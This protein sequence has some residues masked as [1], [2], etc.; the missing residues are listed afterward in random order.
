MARPTPFHPRTSAACQSWAWK[1]WAGHAAVRA[2]DLH[3][4][5]EYFGV[6][7]AAGM[8][9]VSPLYKYDLRGPDAAAL[10]AWLFSR[11]IAKLGV[12]R[13]AYG[14]LLDERGKVLDDGTVSRLG[15]EWF[16][17]TSSEP[18]RGWLV[19]NAEG[20]AVEIH[21]LTETVAAL[22]VQ[23]PASRAILTALWPGVEKL[24]FF[25]AIEVDGAIV[26]RTGYTG[27]LGYEIWVPA[28]EAVALWDALAHAG[29]RYDLRPF[30]LDAL[31]VLRIEAGFVLQGVDYLSARATLLDRRRSTPDE[32]GLGWTVDL[33]RAPFLGQAAIRAERARPAHWSLVGLELSWPGIERLYA[34][35]DLPPH[36]APVA[37][38]ESVPVYDETGRTQVGYA[39]SR[40]WSPITKRYLALATLRGG[41]ARPG[42]RVKIEFTPEFERHQVDALVVEKP[43]YDPPH[44]RGGPK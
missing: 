9:D 28:G 42:S 37:S 36:L 18:W 24:G 26:G 14:C 1:E 19:E 39:T 2:Y 22:A 40:T 27:D 25:R 5:G 11:D 44:K 15:P 7:H 43:F 13:I 4:E 38:R 20:R 6:R 35:L 29:R 12:G 21:D 30:G 23:G 31:D 41:H 8:I 3:S 10:L 17:L 32:V 33:D 34:K 16:R